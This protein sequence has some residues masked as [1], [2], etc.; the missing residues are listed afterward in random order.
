MNDIC[1]WIL[2]FKGTW[3]RRVVAFRTVAA[4]WCTYF[5]NYAHLASRM[6]TLLISFISRTHLSWNVMHMK[7]LRKLVSEKKTPEIASLRSRG[8][9]G[10][11]IRILS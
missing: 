10:G 8:V 11:G 9:A 4:L 7:M 1:N 3:V 5:K 2:S 6:Y